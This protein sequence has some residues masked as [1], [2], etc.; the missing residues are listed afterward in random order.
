MVYLSNSAFLDF[1]LDT[2]GYLNDG[3]DTIQNSKDI[4]NAAINPSNSQSDNFLEIEHDIHWQ[5]VY[6]LTD[7][8]LASMTQKGYQSV[9][10]GECL[11][12]PSANWYRSDSG[13]TPTDPT[14]TVSTDGSCSASV[15]CL[16]SEFGNCC[17]E[18]GFCGSTSAYCGTGCQPASGNCG[19][20]TPPQTVS[21]DGSCSSTVT[22]QGSTFGNCCSSH[23]F[24]GSTSAYCGTGCQPASGSCGSS[25]PPQTISTDGSCSSTVTCQGSTFGNCCSQYG[26]CGSTAGYCG[27]GCKPASGTCS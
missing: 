22:C 7:Y 6:N 16:G 4:W 15:T 2:A 10:V 21:T 13:T 20:N 23:N 1:D 12:D 9:T 8:I 17:S 14:Q 3:A 24:C 26:F 27:T 25:S 19:T 18:H 5:T 11:G